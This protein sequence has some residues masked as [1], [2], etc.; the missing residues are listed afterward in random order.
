MLQPYG[1]IFPW[2]A[3]AKGQISFQPLSQ[4]PTSFT[5]MAS[6]LYANTYS[7]GIKFF[8]A[9]CIFSQTSCCPR[10]LDMDWVDI[11]MRDG[12]G[13]HMSIWTV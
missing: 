2:E 3:Q 6:N 11:S 4:E 10:G 8:F 7:D 5:W 1:R 9:S 12:G 13:V